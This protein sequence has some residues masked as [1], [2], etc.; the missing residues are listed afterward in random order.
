MFMTQFVYDEGRTRDRVSI[1]KD[2][3]RMQRGTWHVRI[4]ALLSVKIFSVIFK[5]TYLFIS[6]IS[7]HPLNSIW[8]VLLS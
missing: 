8:V 1:S 3:K 2:N 6:A 7:D 4:V 5:K